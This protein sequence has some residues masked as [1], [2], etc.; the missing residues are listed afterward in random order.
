MLNKLKNN[1]LIRLNMITNQTT[2]KTPHETIFKKP[3]FADYSGILKVDNEKL[4]QKLKSSHDTMTTRILKS[5][6][7]YLQKRQLV[8]QKNLD[9][10]KLLPIYC[11][12]YRITGILKSRSNVFLNKNNKIVRTSVKYISPVRD[13]E[14]VEYHDP[15]YIDSNERS[16]VDKNFDILINSENDQIN[17]VKNDIDEVKLKG[18]EFC[19]TRNKTIN[20]VVSA[21]A[22]TEGD[23]MN[24]LM[25]TQ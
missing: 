11:D 15:L 1:I 18:G 13:W 19:Q 3:I 23:M 24:P 25:K 9:Q 8:Y 12:P 17:T 5:K 4:L 2:N 16:S 20:K 10:D 6:R 7:R 14:G 21:S 22:C